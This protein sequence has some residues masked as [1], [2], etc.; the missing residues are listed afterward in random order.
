M[1]TIPFGGKKSIKVDE[2]DYEKVRHINWKPECGKRVKRKDNCYA[3]AWGYFS[4]DDKYKKIFMHRFILGVNGDEE[5]DHINGDGL[6]NRRKNL[7]IVSHRENCQNLHFKRTSEYPGVSFNTFANKWTA[8]I[9]VNGVYKH[10]GYFTSEKKA[11]ET[12]KMALDSAKQ[13]E[14]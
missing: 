9:Q 10:L 4:D 3:V 2:G 7:R 6:D 12:Y 11:Y 14:L 5:I 1:I 8:R 13:V